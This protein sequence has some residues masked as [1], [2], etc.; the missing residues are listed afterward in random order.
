[1]TVNTDRDESVFSV[2]T[3]DQIDRDVL[4]APVFAHLNLK[5]FFF[6]FC[7]LFVWMKEWILLSNHFYF[8]STNY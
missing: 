4:H 7:S 6:S 5:V 8:N 2:I 3:G 1:V